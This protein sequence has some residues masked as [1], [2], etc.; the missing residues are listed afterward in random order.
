LD[1]EVEE[2]CDSIRITV[3]VGTLAAV[4][5]CATLETLMGLAGLRAVAMECVTN[6]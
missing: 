5:W 1:V 6:D 3:L 4:G 2:V